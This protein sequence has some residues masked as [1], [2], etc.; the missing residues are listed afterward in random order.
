M[1]TVED[2]Y[3]FLYDHESILLTSFIISST[4]LFIA[5][6]LHGEAIND[7]IMVYVDPCIVVM[8]VSGVLELFQRIYAI[9]FDRC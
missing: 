2:I 5:I 1:I 6:Y 4:W 9:L 3:Q 7:S 8:V